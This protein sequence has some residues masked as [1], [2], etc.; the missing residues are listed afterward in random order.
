[1]E[2]LEVHRALREW[3]RQQVDFGLRVRGHTVQRNLIEILKR[4]DNVAL[5]E[6]TARSVDDLAEAVALHKA[7]GLRRR[8]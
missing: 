2:I 6:R 7:L 5:R 3:T 4:P 8:S 1:V